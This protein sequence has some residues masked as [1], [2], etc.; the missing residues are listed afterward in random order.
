MQAVVVALEEAVVVLDDVE[1]GRRCRSASSTL[2]VERSRWVDVEV[3]ALAVH[4]VGADEPLAAQPLGDADRRISSV[5]G[6]SSE[7]SPMIVVPP[8]MLTGGD[9]VG[10]C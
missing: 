7:P 2:P 5:C 6:E 1:V 4:E 9:Q 3:V 8:G 10:R